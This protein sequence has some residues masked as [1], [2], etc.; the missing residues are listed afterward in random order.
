MGFWIAKSNNL[1]A[2]CCSS[3]PRHTSYVHE[4]TANQAIGANELNSGQ[5][6]R[7]TPEIAPPIPVQ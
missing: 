7:K 2:H 5:V 6:A 1:N 3:S 4:R